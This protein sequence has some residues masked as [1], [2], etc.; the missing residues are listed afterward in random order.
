M[1]LLRPVGLAERSCAQRGF[2]APDLNRSPLLFLPSQ[3]GAERHKDSH[4]CK[5]SSMA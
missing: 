4:P 5:L 1:F 3:P 2:A